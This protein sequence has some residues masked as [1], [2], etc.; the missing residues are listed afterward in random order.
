MGWA[1]SFWEHFWGRDGAPSEE[2]TVEAAWVPL[3]QS[4]FLVD[5]LEAAGVPSAAVEDFGINV[6]VHSR[7]PMARIFVTGDRQDEAEEILTELLGH[8]PRH[9]SV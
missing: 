1:R 6:L 9:R 2:R 4:Q 3:W 7:E 8:A 5:E